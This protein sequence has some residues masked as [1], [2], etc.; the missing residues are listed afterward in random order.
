MYPARLNAQ[1]VVYDRDSKNDEHSEGEPMTTRW[2]KWLAPLLLVVLVA[3]CGVPKKDHEAVL[4]QLEDTQAELAGTQKAKA[5]SEEALN[6][7]ISELDNQIAELTSTRDGLQAQLDEANASLSMYESKT[8]GLEKALKATKEDLNELKKQRAAAEARLRK[9]RQ[10]AAKLANMVQSGKLKVKVRNGKMVIELDA[11][12]TELKD[13]GQA[14]LTELASVLQT[15]KDRAFLVTGHTDNVPTKASKF[16]SN[17]QLSTARAVTVVQYLQGGGVKPDRLAAAGYGEYDPVA[18]ND[19]DE[20]KALNRR[21]EI[22]LMPNIDELP[23]LPDDLF[24]SKS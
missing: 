21:I 6:G 23:A 4:K 12:K 10:L 20:G 5:D 22:V 7:K 1:G 24:S 14:A 9:Y 8:G 2:M 17:W 11:G 15:I 13:D 19:S 18:S 3:G 16:K